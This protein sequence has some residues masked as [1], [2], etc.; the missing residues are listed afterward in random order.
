MEPLVDLHASYL[1]STRYMYAISAAAAA[2]AATA[3]ELANIDFITC[4]SGVISN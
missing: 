2:A 4:R 3:Q 1:K